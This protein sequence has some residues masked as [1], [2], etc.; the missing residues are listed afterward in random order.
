[1]SKETIQ[2]LEKIRALVE[3]TLEAL[4]QSQASKSSRKKRRRSSAEAAEFRAFLKKER[5]NGVPVFDLAKKYK[6][7]ASYIYQ[8]K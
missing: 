4:G 6:V 2:K 1:M 5:D 7:T 8:I 3:E